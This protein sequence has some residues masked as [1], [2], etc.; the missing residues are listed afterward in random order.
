MLVNLDVRRLKGI[1]FFLQKKEL[2][3]YGLVFLL[4]VTVQIKNAL[5]MDLFTSFSLQK[6]LIDGLESC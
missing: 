5:M 6:T 1:Y 3:D 2:L 4:D